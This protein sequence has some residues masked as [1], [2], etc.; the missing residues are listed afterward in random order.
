MKKSNPGP[1]FRFA[2]GVYRIL[3]KALP[4]Q[5]RKQF[6]A[7]MAEDFRQMC[8]DRTRLKAWSRALSDLART[9]VREHLETIRGSERLHP[10]PH[11]QHQKGAFWR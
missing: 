10:N 5:F 3:L 4:R 8:F 6:S 7:D 9:F 2:T 1:R 11:S